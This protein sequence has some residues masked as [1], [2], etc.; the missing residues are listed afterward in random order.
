MNDSWDE[1]SYNHMRLGTNENFQ[2]FL[3]NYDLTSQTPEVRYKSAAAEYYR[4]RVSFLRTYQLCATVKGSPFD[5]P[6][7]GTEE[8][9]K[10]VDIG[11]KASELGSKISEGAEKATSYVKEKGQEMGGAI[12]EKWKEA[13]VSC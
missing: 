10:A 3:K 4:N 5:K 1:S 12:S 8:G 11:S 2:K 7:P 13:T 6:A 9:K